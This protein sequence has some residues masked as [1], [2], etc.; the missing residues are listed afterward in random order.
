MLSCGFPYQNPKL[1][2]GLVEALNAAED[3]VMHREPLKGGISLNY[4][5]ALI[6]ASASEHGVAFAT[7]EKTMWKFEVK[8]AVDIAKY[9][10]Y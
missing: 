1:S 7:A 4:P 3:S 2:I 8:N 10:P 6:V 9:D 5:D